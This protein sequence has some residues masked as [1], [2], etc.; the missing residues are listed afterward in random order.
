MTEEVELPVE[1]PTEPD[2]QD[3]FEELVFAALDSLPKEFKD[4]LGSVA[5][6]VEDEAS[7][8]QL[9]AVGAPGLFGLYTGVPRTVYGADDAPFASKITVFRG[10][11]LRHYR[12]GQSLANGV[13]DTVFHEVAHHFGISDTRLEE[14]ARERGHRH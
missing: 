10:P 9:S 6:V 12:D 7:P 3:P 5:I 13:T 2:P 1:S 14:L 4:R 8:E 11:H